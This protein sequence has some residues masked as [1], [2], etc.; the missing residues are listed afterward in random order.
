[1]PHLVVE[2]CWQILN[3]R[4]ILKFLAFVLQYSNVVQALK[5]GDL[6]L[7]RRALQEHEDRYNYISLMRSGISSIQKIILK[8]GS[9]FPDS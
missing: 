4:C 1:M 2:T 9:L 6:R 5:S 7:L 8:L 3:I